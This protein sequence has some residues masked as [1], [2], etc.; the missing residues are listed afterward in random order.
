MKKV[1]LCLSLIP[2]LHAAP[3]HDTR[4]A[5]KLAADLL[6]LE[7]VLVEDEP[8]ENKFY[9]HPDV[10]SH[11]SAGQNTV[12]KALR[13]D[14]TGLQIRLNSETPH[15]PDEVPRGFQSFSSPDLEFKLT[16]VLAGKSLSKSGLAALADAMIAMLEDAI[17][18]RN[19][20]PCELGKSEDLRRDSERAA[21]ALYSIGVREP[22][23]RIVMDALLNG[24]AAAARPPGRLS[25]K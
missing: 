24:A 6:P 7:S 20:G 14:L 3:D 9:T 25:Y 8:L 22:E 15:R 19:A 17:T 13:N 23:L 4:L 21:T 16:R 11:A 5:S 10:Q 12:I 18:C 1:L 2:A